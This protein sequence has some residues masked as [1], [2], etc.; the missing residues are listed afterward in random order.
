LTEGEEGTSI[1]PYITEHHLNST[2]TIC[3]L[4]ENFAK[5]ITFFA[6]EWPKYDKKVTGLLGDVL[7][8]DQDYSMVFLLQLFHGDMLPSKKLLGQ[9]EQL[10]F[11]WNFHQEFYTIRKQHKEIHFIQL[12]QSPVTQFSS[13]IPS[14]LNGELMHKNI[15]QPL[16]IIVSDFFNGD[17]EGFIQWAYRYDRYARIDTQDE[18]YTNKLRYLLYKY[19]LSKD[20]SMK[21]LL[22]TTYREGQ[23]ASIEH[24]IPRHCK[25]YDYWDKYLGLDRLGNLILVPRSL[26]ISL[27][28]KEVK[29]KIERYKE[30]GLT[31]YSYQEFPLKFSDI[32]VKK[33]R[34]LII[35]LV[36]CREYDIKQFLNNWLGLSLEAWD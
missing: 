27:G 22:R 20:V 4:A 6:L 21:E 29:E 14:Y 25:D 1:I 13:L 5:T 2:E 16:S 11:M 19:E 36:Q 9:W 33:N 15:T 31:S 35:G 23:G 26:N 32:L 18:W 17:D 3:E 24:I 12:F 28:N 10:L 8:L 34:K 30:V 7:I